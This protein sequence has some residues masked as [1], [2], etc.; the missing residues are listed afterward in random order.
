MPSQL[1]QFLVDLLPVVAELLEYVG[2]RL[3]KRSLE[4]RV[5]VEFH[6]KMVPDGVLDLCCLCLGTGSFDKVFDEILVKDGDGRHFDVDATRFQM[7]IGDGP[8]LRRNSPSC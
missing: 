3:R 4:V 1:F 2:Q 7:Q 5:V 6:L 8:Q